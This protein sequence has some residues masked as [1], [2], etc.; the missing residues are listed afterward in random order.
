MIAVYAAT[1]NL[2]PY[3]KVAISSLLAFHKDARVIVLAEDDSIGLPVEVINV[4]SQNYYRADGPNMNSIF[5]YMAAMRLL[6]V[7]LLP[8]IDR[9][10]QLDVDTIVCDSLQPLW[11]MDLTGKWFG[12][13]RE[14]NGNYKPFGTDL[15]YNVGVAVFNLKQMREDGKVPEMVDWLNHNKAWTFEQDALNLF[16][17]GKIA[18]IPPRYNENQFTDLSTNPAVVHYAGYSKWFEANPRMT[19]VEYLIRAREKYLEL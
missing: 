11:E 2:Y 3:L 10:I 1:R 6:Y 15:Y 9:V 18:D 16:G 8:D 7:D 13:C 14:W 19:Q 17:V 5:T 12:A 4:S